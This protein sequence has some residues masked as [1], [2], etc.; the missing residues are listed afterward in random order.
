MSEKITRRS[1]VKGTAIAGAGAAMLGLSG[2]GYKDSAKA[3]AEPKS[4]TYDLVIIGSGGAGLTAAVEAHDKGVT[5]LLVIEKM[6]VCGGNS[7][8]SSSGMNASET[9]AQKAAGIE[10]T[11]ELFINDTYVGGHNMGDMDL[12]TYMC[13]N[14]NAAIE[15]L[16]NHDIVL[17]NLAK[18]GG[19]SVKR[20]HRPTDGSAVGLTLVP[21]LLAN[22]QSRGIDVVYN[23]RVTSLLTDN[24]K[25][26]G[27]HAVDT[28]TLQETDYHAKA[29]IIATGGFGY[30]RDMIRKYQPSIADFPSTNTPGS[31]G[32][33]IIIAQNIGA[34][35]VGMEYIQ[36]H[37][38]VEQTTSTL[39]A[40]AIRGAGAILVNKDAQRF[41]NEE[42]TRDAVSA[43]EL[44]QPDKFSWCMYDAN[45]H[46]KNKACSKY[47]KMGLSKKADTVAGLAQA[48]DLDPTALQA[49]VDAWNAIVAG[50]ATDEFGRK[51]Q[52]TVQPFATA[53]FYAVKIAPGIHHTMGGVRVNDKTEVLKSDG[54]A[55]PGLFAA[56]EVTGGLHGANRLGGNAVC[57][58]VVNGINAGNHAAAY[59]NA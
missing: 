2:C 25:V 29:V 49:T 4:E 42:G 28:Q 53:P 18:M 39:V 12:I 27:A 13:D 54:T 21:G 52:E 33:G 9:A 56:G 10:D 36:T 43:A 38:T 37:P 48:C 3:L 22:V 44:E 35:T 58:I 1:F 6:P 15:W 40:E 23:Q 31:Q 17:D 5:N 50:D 20:C 24:G 8:H 26:A 51:P 47:D 57:D 59:I 11:N 16:G 19:A 41:F 55:I 45:V 32:D 7:S 14:S 34:D 30:N 46:D